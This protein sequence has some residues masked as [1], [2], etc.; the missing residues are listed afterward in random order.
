MPAI[1]FYD[2]TLRDGA[3]GEGVFF[4]PEDKLRI[5][6]KLDA[7]GIDYIEGGWPGSNPKDIEFFKKI[8]DHSFK[9]AKITAFGSTRRA[10]NPPE[11]DR[12]LQNLLETQTEV[13]T[14]FGKSWDL[15]VREVLRITPEENLQ[16]IEDSLAFLRSRGKKV[17]YDAEH[18]FDGYKSDPDYALATLKAAI[19]GGAETLVLCD[20]N[21]GVLPMEFLEI[22]R[23]VREEIQHPLGVHIHNDSGVADAI[24]VMAVQEG[25]VQV[26]GTF[27]GYGERCG[28]ANLSVLIPN[29]L[30]KLGYDSPVRPNLSRLTSTSRFISELTNLQHNERQPYVGGSAFAHKAGTHA[31]AVQ[32]NPAT[33]EHISPELVGNQ[34]RILLS[35]QAGRS[36]ILHKAVDLIPDVTKDDPR[37]KKLTEDLK[38]LEY[39]GYQF[40][41]AE[42]SFELL[43]KKAFALYGKVFSLNGF[44]IIVEKN[45]DG[46][47]RSEATI[48]VSVDGVEEHTAADGEGPVNA[49]DMALR[50]ALLRFFPEIKG[51]K[52]I[53]YKVRVLE[54][55]KGTAA[56]V[57]VL[58]ETT[59]GNEHW[60]TVGVSENIIEASWQALVDSIEYG[61]LK[62]RQRQEQEK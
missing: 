53:D 42:G 29:I 15:H 26:Q 10:D 41:A 59:D 61:I 16:I 48:K 51:F 34:R 28:N 40:E 43:I 56:K 31:D 25:A 17:I 3:Q 24:S 35:D 11:K 13:V 21:G 23:R 52:L 22:F 18:F 20:T 19:R 49:L 30:L 57:R 36:T 37:I 32:K 7:L 62:Q 58:I 39:L 4:S 55:T 60:G 1:V 44:R 6:E 14:I 45:G 33:L 47:A 5:A 12:I 54:E 27:N 46:P 9:H 38:Q 50:K 8:K 2:T